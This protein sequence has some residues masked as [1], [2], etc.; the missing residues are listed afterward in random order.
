[1]RNWLR[2]FPVLVLLGF[3][4]HTVTAAESKA[5]QTMAGILMTLN[6]FPGDAEKQTLKA[7]V[8]DKASTAQEK[9]I[10]QALINVQHKVSAEDK[11]K[12][13]AIMNDQSA[14]AS[15]K[16]L[17]MVIVNLNHMAS[18]TD[19]EKLKPLAS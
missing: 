10:A 8:D 14:P 4:A 16:T 1:M 6:H 19:K 2:V 5:V 13:E 12:L 3:L 18:A 11:P 15:I 9:M 17:A 7:I